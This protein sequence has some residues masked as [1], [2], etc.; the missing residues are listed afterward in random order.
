MYGKD[1]LPLMP[2]FYQWWWLSHLTA[3]GVGF[4]ISVCVNPLDFVMV[5]V[6]FYRF[7]LYLAWELSMERHRKTSVLKSNIWDF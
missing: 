4:I 6:H 5:F 2:S 3:S 1:V 7:G